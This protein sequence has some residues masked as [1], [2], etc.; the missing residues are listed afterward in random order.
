MSTDFPKLFQET[1]LPLVS[2]RL[3]VYGHRLKQPIAPNS[4]TRFSPKMRQLLLT[5]NTLGLVIF[6]GHNKPT[7]V[8]LYMKQSQAQLTKYLNICYKS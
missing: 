7:N 1:D 5:A 8:M 4:P 2:L 3:S 6:M